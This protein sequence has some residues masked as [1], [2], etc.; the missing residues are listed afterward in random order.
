MSQAL[1]I[2]LWPKV[3]EVSPETYQG[4]PHY[5][6]RVLVGRIG[7]RAFYVWLLKADVR[8]GKAIP[9]YF[10]NT[11]QPV[12][13]RHEFLQ[14]AHLEQWCRLLSQSHQFAGS[15]WEDR[16][17]TVDK[18]VML[19]ARLYDG[20]QPSIATILRILRQN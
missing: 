3:E 7:D 15:V 17:K 18:F 11:A 8:G 12:T 6:R 4:C 16:V 19:Q 13:K 20:P 10:E 14:N 9:F 2:E 5:P 1:H